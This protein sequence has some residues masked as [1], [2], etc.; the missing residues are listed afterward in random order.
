MG[1]FSWL[2][3]KVDQAGDGLEHL[4]DSGKKAAGEGADWA[5]HRVGDGLDYV[6]LHDAADAVED[7]GDDLADDLGASVAE[8]QLGRSEEPKE[9]IHGDPKAIQETAGHLRKFGSSFGDVHRGLTRLDPGNWQGEGADAFRVKFEAH[10]KKWL[11]GADACLQAAEALGRFA[12]IVDWAQRQAQTAIDTYRQGKDA[13]KKAVDAYNTKVGAYN[14]D[15]ASYQHLVNG[16][17][18]PGRPPVAPDPF[19]DP[20]A[21]AIAEA[22]EILTEARRQR[23][24]VADEARIAIDAAAELAPAKPEF[25]DRMSGDLQDVLVQGEVEALHYGGGLV[26]SVTDATKFVRGLNPWDTYN[27]THPAEYLT[28]LDSTVAGLVTMAYH[29]ERL[30][31][32]IVGTGWGDDPSESGGRLTGNLVM[33]L[34]T[35]GTSTAA[36]AAER[37]AMAAG[38]DAAEAVA[39]RGA[40]KSGVPAA[41]P[42]AWDDLA[43][44]TEHVTQKAIHADSVDA[45]TA[46]EFVDDQYPWLK[47]M[48]SDRYEAKTPGYVDNCSNNVIAVDQRLDGHEVS[49]APLHE[50]RWPD[51]KALGNPDAAWQNVGSYDDIIGDMGARGEGSRGIV[52][53]ERQNKTAHVFNVIHDSHG[54]VFLDGQTGAL[55]RLEELNNSEF[56]VKSI[57]YMP[58]K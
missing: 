19:H 47:D 56:G 21:T 35:G 18:D 16:E 33:A 32:A 36:T 51:P 39:E 2:E 45:A 17:G 8:Q 43:Q 50:P 52:Y 27:V 9:L 1:A 26:R 29:P 42:K 46:R 14:T 53:V 6:G 12:D 38:R 40:V 7:F 48:N 3:D 34:A 41:I 54:V 13:H 25:T 22:K 20:G 44:P 49:T 24:A 58:Y 57:K 28:H 30:P 23:D 5:A 31:Q 15:L 37:T 10:P 55:G 4:V 11:Q